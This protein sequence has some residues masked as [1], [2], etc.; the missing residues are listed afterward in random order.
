MAALIRDEAVDAFG[1]YPRK[2]HTVVADQGAAVSCPVKGN[3][4]VRAQLK[5]GDDYLEGSAAPAKVDLRVETGPGS[6]SVLGGDGDDRIVG[7]SLTGEIDTLYGG[8][9]DD[10]VRGAAGD[11]YVRGNAG[12]DLIVAG[13]GLNFVIGDGGRDDMRGGA[14][15]DYMTGGAG[16]DVM[17]GGGAFDNLDG[18]RGGDEISGQAGGDSLYGR[19]GED[20]LRGGADDDDFYARDETADEVVCGD[21]ADTARVDVALDIVR[22]NCERVRAK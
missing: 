20:V 7:G 15:I 9:G 17:L 3:L 11:D 22:D 16:D 2:C 8:Y 14:G 13:D 10:E 12:A 1:G 18:G 6:N 4:L 21:G 5:D 19:A